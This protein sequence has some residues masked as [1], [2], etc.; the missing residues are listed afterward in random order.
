MVLP[1][2]TVRWGDFP[3]WVAALGTVLAFLATVV[4]LWL[5]YRAL[6][7]VE[8]DRRARD[9][10]DRRHQARMVAAWCLNVRRQAWA[11]PPGTEPPPDW[12]TVSIAYT[13]VSD[14]PVYD[15]SVIVKEHWGPR[16]D[17]WVL[18]LGVVGPRQERQE[19]LL[20]PIASALV[21][22]GVKPPVEVQFRDAA[23]IAWRRAD[24]GA[25]TNL[26]REMPPIPGHEA[27]RVPPMPPMPPW[28]GPVG[29][30]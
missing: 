6:K 3:T 15:V 27:T 26:G 29:A 17:S 2:N 25:L 16:T 4:L 1:V 18:R 10:D 5:Q 12:P 11:S 22:E 13:N 23:G 24:D 9:D 20:V 21:K 28:A 7:D 30:S 8:S 19:T 14:E